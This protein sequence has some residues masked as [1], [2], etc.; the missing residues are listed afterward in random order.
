MNAATPDWSVGDRVAIESAGLPTRPGTVRRV[1]AMHVVVA[2]DDG[3]GRLVK[4][5]KKTGR[6]VAPYA[7][8]STWIRPWTTRDGGTELQMYLD[9]TLEDLQRLS[10]LVKHLPLAELLSVRYSLHKTMETVLATLGHKK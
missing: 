10:V 6:K 2:A 5:S 9:L 3:G 7:Q 1:S 8:F 4:F